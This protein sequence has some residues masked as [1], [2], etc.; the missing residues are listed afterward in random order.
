MSDQ[1]ARACL[2][3]LTETR[4]EMTDLNGDGALDAP[5]LQ[6]LRRELCRDG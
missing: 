4:F 6:G 5:V 3:K 1:E 2:P